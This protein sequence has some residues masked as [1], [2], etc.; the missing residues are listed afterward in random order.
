MSRET[1]TLQALVSG[2]IT[3]ALTGG[4][5][6][7]LPAVGFVHDGDARPVEGAA[8]RVRADGLY[9][10]FG[11]P[12]RLPSGQA[13][14]LRLNVSA[15]GYTTT[16]LGVALSAADTALVLRVFPLRGEDTAAPVLAAP[17]RDADLAL[18][19]LPVFLGGRVSRAEDGTALAGA[20]IR[21]IA[22]AAVGPVAS[23]AD[24][25]FTLGPAPV[26]ETVTL[27]IA[28]AGRDPLTAEVRLDFRNPVNPGAYAL[29]PS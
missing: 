28:A 21:I 17:A 24:G 20:E 7:S 25:F 2:R 10:V 18:S 9:A 14:A 15:E 22:P 27:R 16:S 19:P 11:D 1:V 12:L 26:A 29:E 13:L 4:A 3:D 6:R 5:P 8:V 23:D